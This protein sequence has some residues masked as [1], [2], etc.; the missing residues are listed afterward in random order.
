MSVISLTHSYSLCI[1]I[2]T[3]IGPNT[4]LDDPE[5]KQL[6]AD[7]LENELSATVEN[8]ML[9]DDGSLSVPV[10]DELSRRNQEEQDIII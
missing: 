2:N 6:L 8:W 9:L 4:N 3:C 1:H 10:V 5:L 7:E